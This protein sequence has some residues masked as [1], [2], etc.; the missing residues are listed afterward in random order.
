M[1]VL[2]EPSRDSIF[3][4]ASATSCFDFAALAREFRLGFLGG[5][6]R[7]FQNRGDLRGLSRENLFGFP[8]LRCHVRKHILGF[9]API[10]LE[11]FDRRAKLTNMTACILPKLSEL[12]VRGFAD[13]ADFPVDGFGERGEGGIFDRGGSLTRRFEGFFEFLVNKG[14]GR[15]RLGERRQRFV[16]YRVE[17]RGGGGKSILQLGK[18]GV[19]E[20]S[21]VFRASGRMF[22][23][24]GEVRVRWREAL[25][26]QIQFP[27][28]SLGEC[29]ILVDAGE[30]SST[31]RS[32]P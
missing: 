22:R 25:L 30:V 5:F 18:N 24:G 7:R 16:A 15:L 13:L 23:G 32:Y 2:R 6:R 28:H 21:I 11:L 19:A 3:A 26:G 14:A 29:F 20:V 8:E 31:G 4:S 27:V 12:L 17:L 10:F 1:D 9:L